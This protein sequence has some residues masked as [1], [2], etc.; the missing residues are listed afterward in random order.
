MIYF[1]SRCENGGEQST[2]CRSLKIEQHDGPSND[3]EFF[4]ISTTQVETSKKE[5]SEQIESWFRF[6]QGNKT[7]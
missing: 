3:L 4:K 6:K 7:D 5:T 2:D 1:K